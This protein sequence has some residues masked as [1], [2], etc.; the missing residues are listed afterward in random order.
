F[1][2]A[3]E[4]IVIYPDH[5]SLTQ[6]SNV[7]GTT[8]TSADRAVQGSGTAAVPL[9]QA[10]GYDGSPLISSSYRD[11]ASLTA[12]AATVRN[13]VGT[14][15]TTP[16]AAGSRLAGRHGPQKYVRPGGVLPNVV[17]APDVTAAPTRP[18]VPGADPVFTADLSSGQPVYT[19]GTYDPTRPASLQAAGPGE[20]GSIWHSIEDFKNNVIHGAEKVA[21]IAW[22]FAGEVVTTVIHT[23]EAEYDL[24]ISDLEDAVTA[25]AGF[26]KSVVDDI[27]KAIEWLS[28]LFNF[29]NILKNH[30]Y[31]K[32]AITNPADPAHPGILDRLLTWTSG[33]LNGGTD[34]TSA[35][36]QLSGHSSAAVGSTA[37]G[38]A[39]QTVQ[40]QQNGNNDSSTVY[41]TGGNNNANQCTWM[42][43]KVTENTVG[44][45]GGGDSAAAL[46]ASFDPT[47]ITQ[48]FETFVAAAAATLKQD[49]ADLPG[50]I[51]QAVKSVADSFKDPKTLLSTALSDLMTVF[52]DLADDFVHLT[53]DLASDILNL[54]ATLLE[55]I[56]L[57]LTEP[58]SIPFVSNLYQALTGDPLSVLDLTCLLAAVPGTILLDVIT[59]SPTVPATVSA[60]PAAAQPGELT[61]SA[62][63]AGKILLG[64]TAFAIG[65]VGLVIDTLLLGV[66]SRSGRTPWPWG[67]LN[68]LDFAI[69]FTGYAL[70][71][72]TA[73]GWSAWEAQDWAFWM[74][75][76]VPQAFNFAYQFRDDGT[77]E[78]QAERDVFFG[79]ILLIFSAVYAHD[80]PS[81]YKD[82]PKA[83]GLVLSANVFGNASGI[84]ELILL[85]FGYDQMPVQAVVKIVL[86]TVGN[87][88]GFTADVLGVV[89]S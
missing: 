87:I 17:Y 15:T 61:G 58:V 65:E 70:Q 23:A 16:A 32:N 45:P 36:S 77:N 55:Q 6:L 26:F 3:G 74:W 20:L 14:R 34:F 8:T 31:I 21:K 46:G 63:E 11:P 86:G 69:D 73:F 37:Q 78:K 29:E 19:A 85:L 44:N 39:G 10:T 54:I 64:I 75:Q 57:W 80:W 25:V 84:C 4:A 12:I 88:L 52:Q 68:R 60:A 33:E 5:E 7:Q 67:F 9:D 41:N 53:Q 42:H 47:Q 48:A 30:A 82:A 81:S 2:A 28:A 50:Q 79:I 71:M 27:K 43:Q 1:M 66:E 56:V 22:K 38:A 59:G 35:L 40:S 83:P 51:E 62:A 18:Y 49:F 13:T 72:V 76:S 89:D 24:A